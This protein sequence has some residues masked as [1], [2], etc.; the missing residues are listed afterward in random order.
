MRLITRL[1]NITVAVAALLIAITPS[2]NAHDN[3][4]S[5]HTKVAIYNT[6][7]DACIQ[8]GVEQDAEL[9]SMIVMDDEM[10]TEVVTMSCSCI[11]EA[12]SESYSE[13]IPVAELQLVM[14][15]KVMQCMQP[16]LKPLLTNICTQVATQQQMDNIDE[17]CDCA[18]SYISQSASSDANNFLAN[19]EANMETAIQYCGLD[20]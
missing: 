2:A 3:D 15:P 18:G 9:Q 13:D 7:Y 11:A 20:K 14:Q 6:V 8:D 10:I 19:P 17:K 1:P 16:T 4:N 5:A 12:F